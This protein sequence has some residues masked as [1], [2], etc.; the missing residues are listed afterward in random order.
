MRDKKHQFNFI[1]LFAGCGGLSEGFLQS[2]N[3]ESLAQ[4]EW[5]LPIKQKVYA[6]HDTPYIKYE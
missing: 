5:E 1:D 2:G 3:F 6:L 4:V